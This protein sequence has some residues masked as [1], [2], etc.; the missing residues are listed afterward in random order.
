[1]GTVEDSEETGVDDQDD[2]MDELDKLATKRSEQTGETYA[3]AFTKIYT[4]PAY[5]RLASKE[6]IAGRAKINKAMGII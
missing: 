1:M 3:Q 4:S 6:R 5:A 2:A